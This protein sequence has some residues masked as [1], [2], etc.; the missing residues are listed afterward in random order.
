[1]MNFAF[2]K[3]WTLA[4]LLASGVAGTAAVEDEPSAPVSEAAEAL[5]RR[6]DVPAIDLRRAFGLQQARPA[7]PDIEHD[8]R[9]NERANDHAR[10][11]AERANER[12]NDHARRRAERANERPAHA[13]EDA[14]SPDETRG[15]R[16]GHTLGRG[17]ELSRGRGHQ[18]H[19]H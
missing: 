11:R 1:M 14:M 4:G 9:A 12:A 16:L 3:P 5:P 7:D 15:R 8:E 19:G 2:L 13:S 18:R 17:H 6:A 10:R